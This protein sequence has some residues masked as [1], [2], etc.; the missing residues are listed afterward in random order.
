MSNAITVSDDIV[1]SKIYLIRGKNVM[2][3]RDLAQMYGVET[4]G[5]N[6]A[7]KRNKERFPPD[8][9]FQMTPQELENW[10]SQIVTSNKEK[11]GIRKLPY[12]F[13]EMGVAMLSSVLKSET[14]VEVN[15]QIIRIFSR[16]REVLLTHNDVLLKIAQLE[17]TILNQDEKVNKHEEE[18]QMIFNALKQLLNQPQEPRKK[19]GFKIGMDN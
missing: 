13:T 7:V 10:M 16:I 2:L 9:M 12:V 11:M 1:V 3:D 5:L 15:I 8:F 17:R 4:K 19:I 14:A 18:I 6:Q